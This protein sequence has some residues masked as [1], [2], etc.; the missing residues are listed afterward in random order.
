ML[1]NPPL[2]HIALYGYTVLL[3]FTVFEL[4]DTFKNPI[5]LVGSVLFI[6]GLFSLMTYHFRKIREGKN[7]NN[8]LAQRNARLIAHTTITLFFVIT[9]FPAAKISFQFYDAFGLS[10]HAYLTYAVFNRSTPLPGVVLLALYF[11]A[12]TL[13]KGMIG[14][15]IG[16]ELLSLIGSLLL[17]VYFTVSSV[18]GLESMFR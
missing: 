6:I 9:L 17:L 13:C 3:V 16:M 8:D 14:R 2:D 11:A 1:N 10:A 12:A 4:G 15:K 7:E 5:D 18:N